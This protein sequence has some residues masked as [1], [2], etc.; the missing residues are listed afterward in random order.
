MQPQVLKIEVVEPSPQDLSV[1]HG[2][3]QAKHHEQPQIRVL[4]GNRRAQQ[5]ISFLVAQDDDPP[6][7]LLVLWDLAG[8]RCDPLPLDRLAEE[9]RKRREFP[10]DRADSRAGLLPPLLVALNRECR[11]GVEPLGAEGAK[12]RNAVGPEAFVRGG[13]SMDFLSATR[14]T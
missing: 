12:E 2:G 8:F 5:S 7:L 3:V 1:T 14:P 10:I 9:V 11:N 4:V 13:R 6:P